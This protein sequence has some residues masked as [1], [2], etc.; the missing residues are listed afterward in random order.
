MQSAGPLIEPC[1][2]HFGLLK[3]K[4][5]KRGKKT[6]CVFRNSCHFVLFP[7]LFLAFPKGNDEWCLLQRGAGGHTRPVLFLSGWL[8]GKPAPNSVSPF[9][10]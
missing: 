3:E 4:G 5:K 10:P 1:T 6:H 7:A 8:K 2:L 9:P